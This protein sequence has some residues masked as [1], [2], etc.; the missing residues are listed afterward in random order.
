MN[1]IAKENNIDCNFNKYTS[2]GEVKRTR[3][4]NCYMG[5]RC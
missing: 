5:T 1:Y 4:L 2:S 3:I